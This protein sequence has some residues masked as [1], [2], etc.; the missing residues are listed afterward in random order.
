MIN[1]VARPVAFPFK[2]MK[3]K[4]LASLRVLFSA[5]VWILVGT[6]TQADETPATATD[7]GELGTTT[8]SGKI[9]G[10]A[11]FGSGDK[12]DFYQFVPRY[13]GQATVTFA[14]TYGI[15][16]NSDR[17]DLIVRDNPSST[18]AIIP[19]VTKTAVGL[20]ETR[21]TQRHS[22][23]ALAGQTYYIGVT[24][25]TGFGAP[26]WDYDLKVEGPKAPDNVIE[27]AIDLGLLGA[28]SHNDTVG[29]FFLLGKSD[30]VDYY[31]FSQKLSGEVTVRVS[32]KSKGDLVVSSPSAT[33]RNA[34][35]AEINSTSDVKSIINIFTGEK[36]V[37]K[38][39]KFNGVPG[40]P[41]YVK[42]T[43]GTG[44]GSSSYNYTLSVETPKTDDD[45]EFNNSFAK[46]FDLGTLEGKNF[47]PDLTLNT[48]ADQDFFK[49]R[50]RLNGFATVTI[51]YARTFVLVGQEAPAVPT[52]DVLNKAQNPILTTPLLHNPFNLI[53]VTSGS[54]FP[55]EP[56]IDYYLHVKL[57]K[58]SGNVHRYALT[59][60]T[61]EL[62]VPEIHLE[63][64]GGKMKASFEDPHNAFNM[65]TSTTLQGWVNASIN[66]SG[67]IKSASYNLPSDRYFRIKEKSAGGGGG[68]IIPR[69]PDIIGEKP[70]VD[71]IPIPD[72]GP[73]IDPGSIIF[74]DLP[75]I[76]P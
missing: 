69:L 63:R 70:I 2:I 14:F 73:I 62:I 26:V 36:T 57:N 1:A 20:V 48:S 18:I 19:D 54:S 23:A 12:W 45:F 38:S 28:A 32:Y 9:G 33:I 16:D 76:F 55:V 29:G 50:S 5:L 56:G 51:S 71:I 60:A 72:P 43:S 24:G 58:N 4:S 25:A 34:S 31:Q 27:G 13:S 65:Q 49:F 47:L 42:V 44:L 46:A 53:T 6:V 74:P 40:T 68:V 37:S 61:P 7:L 75:P 30:G 21:E 22:F 15:F 67:D 52:F 64:V 59:I 17:P 35:D 3:T 8:T 66:T 11:I 41:Y 39:Y 10:L